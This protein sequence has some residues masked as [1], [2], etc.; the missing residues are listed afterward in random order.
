MKNASMYDNYM[1]KII[2]LQPAQQIAS[3]QKNGL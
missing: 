1:M 2:L 3:K